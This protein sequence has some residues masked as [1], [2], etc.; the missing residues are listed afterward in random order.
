[1]NTSPI[2]DRDHVEEVRVALKEAI[3]T[4]KPQAET[5]SL[6]LPGFEY[7]PFPYST[8]APVFWKQERVSHGRQVRFRAIGPAQ[9]GLHYHD[10]A[11]VL[12]ACRG[13]LY[14]TAGGSSRALIPGDTYT[15]QPHEIHKAEFRDAGEALAYWTDLESDELEMSFFR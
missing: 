7:E 2:T 11:E 12:I 1:M 14:Y 5:V 4:Y 10:V 13:I 8:G 9:I 6:S 15:A 3:N